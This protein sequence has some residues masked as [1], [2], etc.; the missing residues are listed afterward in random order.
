MEEDGEQ[1]LVPGASYKLKPRYINSSRS[2]LG[3]CS[4]LK[5]LSDEAPFALWCSTVI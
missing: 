2:V 1:L 3:R 4:S 5:V